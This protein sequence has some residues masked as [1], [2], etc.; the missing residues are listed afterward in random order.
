MK[1]NMMKLK[2]LIPVG[3]ERS[4]ASTWSD[5]FISLQQEVERLFDDFGGHFGVSVQTN[6]GRGYFM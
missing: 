6:D 5:P 1:G 4:L 3:R 2:S